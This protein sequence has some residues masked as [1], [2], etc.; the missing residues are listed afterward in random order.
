MTEKEKKY[1]SDILHSVELIETF[2]VGII[3]FESYSKDEK[4]K[5]Q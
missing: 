4:Q 1:L 2:V 5:V 3:S